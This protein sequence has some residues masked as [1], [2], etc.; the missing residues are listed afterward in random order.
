[1]VSVVVEMVVMMLF[2]GG[3]TLVSRLNAVL[4]ISSHLMASTPTTDM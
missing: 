3:L 1:M 2:V 4:M